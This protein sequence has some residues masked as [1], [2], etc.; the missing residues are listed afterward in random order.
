MPA[1]GNN[2]AVD[3]TLSIRLSAD[4]LSFFASGHPELPRGELF[5][6]P[7]ERPGDLLEKLRR[8]GRV[9]FDAFARAVVEV[10]SRRM[11]LVPL[12][13][14]EEG[15]QEDYL[16][17]NGIA[18]TASEQVVATSPA[19]GIIALVVLPRQVV[20]FCRSVWDEHVRF[21]SPIAHCLE[22]GLHATLRIRVERHYAYIARYA[23]R[24]E[25]AVVIPCSAPADLLYYMGGL[26]LEGMR[27]TWVEV[28][29]RDSRAV[30]K[31]LRRY[32][33]RVRQ[34]HA[35]R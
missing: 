17:V 12:E 13:A 20:D 23:E 21:A 24:L 7:G 22:H 9:D 26:G 10:N 18:H 28:S 15:M 27:R 25:E 19:P 5:V 3:T 34:G 2:P 8:T 35:H 29:G 33:R 30:M 1:T 32:Y 16:A 6:E 11:L 31:A 4:G 14:F